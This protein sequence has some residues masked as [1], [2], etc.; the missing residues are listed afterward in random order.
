VKKRTHSLFRPGSY[1]YGAIPPMRGSQLRELMNA[2]VEV[3]QQ[4]KVL[5][6]VFG[7]T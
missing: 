1:W 7:V 5:R 3:M 4:Y 6:E 2:F